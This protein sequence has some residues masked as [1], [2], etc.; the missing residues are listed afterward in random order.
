MKVSVYAYFHYVFKSLFPNFK[1][2]I[3]ISIFQD[4]FCSF[5]VEIKQ[6][7][8]YLEDIILLHVFRL[9]LNHAIFMSPG[10]AG[11]NFAMPVNEKNLEYRG[12][13]I[14]TRLSPSPQE[15][16]FNL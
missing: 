2:P 12:C 10:E 8:L 7:S 13:G 3:P 9:F 14:N 15:L 16:N 1:Y 11:G 6:V 4:F 5:T